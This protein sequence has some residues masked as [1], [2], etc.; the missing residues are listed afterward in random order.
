MK[1]LMVLAGIFIISGFSC[2]SKTSKTCQVDYDCSGTMVCNTT[3]HKCEPFVC[4]TN[5]DCVGTHLVCRSNRCV[6][7]DAV[8]PSIDAIDHQ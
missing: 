5:S 4:K 2:S 3:T 8:E 7:L 6:S 1:I